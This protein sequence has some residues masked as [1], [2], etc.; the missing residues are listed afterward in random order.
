M[1]NIRKI[2]AVESTKFGLGF[3]KQPG[4]PSDNDW[5]EK[6]QKLASSSAAVQD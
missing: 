2:I 4:L 1:L 3:S 5:G 6:N